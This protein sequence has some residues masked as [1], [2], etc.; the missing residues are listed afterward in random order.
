M[1]L[2]HMTPYTWKTPKD[3]ADRLAELQELEV[4]AEFRILCFQRTGKE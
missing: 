4:T 3:G 1:A 2:F